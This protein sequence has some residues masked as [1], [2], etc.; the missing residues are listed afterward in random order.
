VVF[1]CTAKQQA[2]P[3]FFR[4]VFRPALLFLDS[5]QLLAVS[6]QLILQTEAGFSCRSEKRAADSSIF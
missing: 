6:S 2:A 1:R 5:L 3:E 4:P